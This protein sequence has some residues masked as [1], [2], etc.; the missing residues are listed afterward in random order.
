MSPARQQ[1]SLP[2]RKRKRSDEMFLR[3]E[4]NE[5]TPAREKNPTRRMN[6]QT[7]SQVASAVQ[8]CEEKKGEDISILEM[9]KSSSAF[10]DYFVICTGRNPRQVQAIADEVELRLK[11]AGNAANQVEGYN[12]ADWILID[13][14]DFVVHIFSEASRKFY[15]LERLWKSAK[16]V[17]LADLKK[18]VAR[19][20]TAAKVEPITARSKTASTARGTKSGTT[21]QT[22]AA[23]RRRK[24]S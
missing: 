14:V 15:D 1:K 4:S 2:L 10:T 3:L 11:K 24:S 18:P 19:P 9:D 21:A 22:R 20:R 23:G 8:A 16:K 6:A 5:E 17:T 12:Q 7:R 13:F